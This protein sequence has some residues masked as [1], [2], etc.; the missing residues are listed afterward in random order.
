MEEAVVF[1]IEIGILYPFPLPL[2]L[3]HFTFLLLVD[4]PSS[5][6]PFALFSSLLFLYSSVLLNGR[7]G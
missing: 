2:R 3:P 5:P 7:K 1:G 4:L 6:L